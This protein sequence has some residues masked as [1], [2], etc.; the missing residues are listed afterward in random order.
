MPYFNYAISKNFQEMGCKSDSGRFWRIIVDK[1]NEKPYYELNDSGD[2]TAFSI[3]DIILN[4]EN[5][6]N[7]W[8]I[9]EETWM[10]KVLQI[11]N[12]ARLTEDKERTINNFMANEYGYES[13][14]QM[15][16]P[17]KFKSSSE[18]YATLEEFMMA[19]K[20]KL[21]SLATTVSQKTEEEPKDKNRFLVK[22]LKYPKKK[23]KGE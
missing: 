14:M 19:L 6:K 4:E 11:F 20:R 9:K 3:D 22:F 10:F 7:I 2:I 8:G 5:A 21:G 17:E 15:I 23:P 16:S 12:L 13:E 1:S 18:N